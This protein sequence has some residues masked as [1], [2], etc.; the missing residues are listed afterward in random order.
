MTWINNLVIQALLDIER[1]I[2]VIPDI[3]E[4]KETYKNLTPEFLQKELHLE[5]KKQQHKLE[6]VKT[7][8]VVFPE[9]FE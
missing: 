5:I 4:K 7:M 8:L 2:E 1:S 3:W 6:Q 9:E